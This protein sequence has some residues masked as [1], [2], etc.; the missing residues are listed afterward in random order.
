[1]NREKLYLEHHIELRDTLNKLLGEKLFLKKSP[2]TELEVTYHYITNWI[3]KDL[4]PFMKE[5]ENELRKR[6]SE[7]KIIYYDLVKGGK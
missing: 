2:S 7:E 3:K 1:L 4:I 6:G 5:I